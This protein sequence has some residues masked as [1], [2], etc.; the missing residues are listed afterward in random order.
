MKLNKFKQYSIHSLKEQRLFERDEDD[1]F[2]S[3]GDDAYL[4]DNPFQS[5]F[6]SD[7]FDFDDEDYYDLDGYN[8]YGH[9]PEDDKDEDYDN[10]IEED[11][12]GNLLYLL[13]TMFRNSG[14]ENV[15]V[16]NKKMDIIISV[17]MRR[18]ENLKDI[19]DVFTVA[20][21]LKKDIL[22]QYDSE[23]EVW[24]S[25]TGNPVFVFNFY[26]D[27]GLYDDEAPF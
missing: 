27:E 22:A 18:R 14:I 16:E 13:R 8:R 3:E 12:M 7:D 21:K 11:D 10:P 19:M 17:E 20:K 25:K 23:F 9:G 26:Y 2:Y 24:S 15:E 6:S 5:R 1:D 4:N